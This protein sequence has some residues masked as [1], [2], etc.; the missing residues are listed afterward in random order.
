[1]K[2]RDEPD[3]V[4]AR[5]ASDPPRDLSFPKDPKLTL[6]PNTWTV[7]LSLDTASHWAFEENAI[8]YTSAL[9]APRRTYI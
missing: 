1:M 7:P 8:L 9:S 5:L 6:S 2:E 3:D 4:T